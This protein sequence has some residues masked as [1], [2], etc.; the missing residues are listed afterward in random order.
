[1]KNWDHYREPKNVSY[2]GYEETKAFEAALRAEINFDKP[3][4]AAA[5]EKA[6]ADVK[7][8]VREHAAEQNKPYNEAKG[9]LEAEFWADAREELGYEA[10]LTAEGVSALEYKAY[11]D[12]HSSGHSEVFSQLQDLA[13]F[14]EKM[15]KAAKN[16]ARNLIDKGLYFLASPASPDY[17]EVAS[18]SIVNPQD[19]DMRDENGTMLPPGA[20]VLFPN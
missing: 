18:C 10:F 5:R 2:F 6:L 15:T 8:Q 12:G 7:R 19:S 14:A 20:T 16:V 3:L 17:I 9:K 4:T 1:M 13:D 11:E